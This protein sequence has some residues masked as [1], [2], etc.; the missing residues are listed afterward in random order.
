MLLS[1]TID[2]GIGLTAGKKLVGKTIPQTD[3]TYLTTIKLREKFIQLKKFLTIKQQTQTDDQ[4]LEK[5]TSL[6]AKLSEDLEQ[7]KTITQ[8]V[9]NNLTVIKASLHQT[10]QD[11]KQTKRIQSSLSI[12]RNFCRISYCG[13]FRLSIYPLT[14]LSIPFHIHR[15]NCARTV[16]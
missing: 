11:I 13:D 5:L 15:F 16:N 9:T 2:S 7:Q 1:A 10:A 8:T 6:V 12:F 3:D 4:Q 14:S